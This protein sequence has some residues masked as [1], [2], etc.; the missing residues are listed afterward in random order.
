MPGMNLG[1]SHLSPLLALT[2]L[3]RALQASQALSILQSI[4]YSHARPGA[5]KVPLDPP[6]PQAASA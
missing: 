3:L 1:G 5:P 4:P 6:T 2:N